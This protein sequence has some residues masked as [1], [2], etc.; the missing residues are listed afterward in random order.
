MKTDQNQTL[1]QILDTLKF[2]R[3]NPIQARMRSGLYNLVPKPLQ[4][5]NAKYNEYFFAIAVQFIILKEAASLDSLIDEIEYKLESDTYEFENHNYGL[6]FLFQQNQDDNVYTLN[7]NQDNQDNLLILDLIDKTWKLAQLA[8]EDNQRARYNTNILN[9]RNFKKLLNKFIYEQNLHEEIEFIKTGQQR[10]EI[11]D[12]LKKKAV[13]KNVKRTSLLIA[14]L[15]AFGEA[16]VSMVAIAA[17]GLSGPAIWIIFA[18]AFIVNTTLFYSANQ[19]LFKDFFGKTKIKKFDDQGKEYLDEVS[20]IFIDSN[21]NEVSRTKKFIMGGLIFFAMS[22]GIASGCLSFNSL[23]VG[24]AILLTAAFP[25]LGISIIAGFLSIVATVALTALFYKALSGLIKDNERQNQV[26]QWLFDKFIKVW[27]EQDG[28]NVVYFFQ[29]KSL[30]AGIKSFL[31]GF[32][33]SIFYGGICLSAP[34]LIATVFIFAPGALMFQQ[35]IIQTF[36]ALG[37][38]SLKPIAFIT[39]VMTGIVE[40]WFRLEAI[41]Y[42]KNKVISVTKSLINTIKSLINNFDETKEEL[43]DRLQT[44]ETWIMAPIET[45]TATAIVANSISQAA[46]QIGAGSANNSIANTIAP[47]LI[48]D[49]CASVIAGVGVSCTSLGANTE[50]TEEQVKNNLVTKA[51]NTGIGFFKTASFEQTNDAV[52][53]SNNQKPVAG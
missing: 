48:S 30:Y 34:L 39:T 11:N 4:I 46:L 17:F 12:K 13:K 43:I 51:I 15:V 36:P 53:E 26:K 16:M 31:K 23:M 50:A 27:G 22:A 52:F 8:Y 19:S 21:G 20:N 38:K 44:P 45:V 29:Q 42:L 6:D 7:I 40:S 32:C 10:E 35:Q 28:D 49:N 37:T 14:T 25:P 9:L 41:L 3:N 18:T 5:K 33:A 24:L 2:V 47:G 1:Q